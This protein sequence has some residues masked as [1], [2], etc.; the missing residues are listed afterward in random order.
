[1]EHAALGVDFGERHLGAPRLALSLSGVGAGER[2]VH[3]DLDGRFAQ[4][5]RQQRRREHGRARVRRAALDDGATRKPDFHAIPPIFS[6]GESVLL[7]SLCRLS[8][9]HIHCAANDATI[10]VNTRQPSEADPALLAPRN[11]YSKILTG[12]NACRNKPVRR[13]ALNASGQPKSARSEP[14]GI[15]PEFAVHPG[16]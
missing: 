10:E 16:P 9:R 2:I 12:I 15:A 8:E 4:R 1:T 13:L 6:I 5:V 7:S 14:A 11:L 3:S